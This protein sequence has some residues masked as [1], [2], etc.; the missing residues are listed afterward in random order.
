MTNPRTAYRENDVRGATALRLV[1]LLYEQLVLDL[2]QALH[3]LENHDIELRTH[4]INHAILIIGH[5]QSP[6]D[7][8]NGGRVAQ[9][10]DN[11][12]NA[13]RQ[14]LVY[15]QFHPSKS[16]I[17]QQITDLLALREAWIEVERSEKAPMAVRTEGTASTAGR[18]SIPAHVDWKG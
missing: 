4:R 15:V 6:L 10:L 13:L 1:V 5:L 18:E 17:R 8:I 9:D 16:G 14:N 2:R 3:A 11:F 12:Y 7:F